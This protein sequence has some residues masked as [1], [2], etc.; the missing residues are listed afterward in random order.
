VYIDNPRGL[1]MEFQTYIYGALIILNL[2]LTL[3][4]ALLPYNSLA[5]GALH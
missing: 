3:S 2:L 5:Y 4:A 1:T